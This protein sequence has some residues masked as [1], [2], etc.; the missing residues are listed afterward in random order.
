MPNALLRSFG[1]VKVVVSSDS[2]AGTS[3]AANAP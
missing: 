3:S 1:L 2:P